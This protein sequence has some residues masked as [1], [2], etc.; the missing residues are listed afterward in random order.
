ML[1]STLIPNRPVIPDGVTVDN[2]IYGPNIQSLKGKTV[3]RHPTLVVMYYITIPPEVI[4]EH[5]DM[6]VEI[7]AMYVNKLMFVVSTSQ[8][9]L[10][11]T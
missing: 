6:T 1:C 5:E 7:D 3:R 8:S 9:I 2:K 10:F 4:E 11:V